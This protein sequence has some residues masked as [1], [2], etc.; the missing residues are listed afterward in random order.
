MYPFPCS[1]GVWSILYFYWTV[2][3]NRRRWKIKYIHS[4][5]MVVRALRANNAGRWRY[6]NA[7]S[8]MGRV[9]PSQGVVEAAHHIRCGLCGTGVA[10]VIKA[11]AASMT[12]IQSNERVTRDVQVTQR[13]WTS[14]ECSAQVNRGTG[15]TTAGDS[16]RRREDSAAN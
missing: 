12:R 6:Q 2:L 5:Q 4:E 14:P 1:Q 13:L 3:L 15:R 8:G 10:M 9:P 11:G 7:I 16:V